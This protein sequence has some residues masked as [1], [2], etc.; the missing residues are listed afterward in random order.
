MCSSLLHASFSDKVSSLSLAP[1]FS[2]CFQRNS[3]RLGSI[4]ASPRHSEN[5]RLQWL[6]SK[7]HH[8]I[9]LHVFVVKPLCLICDLW[10]LFCIICYIFMEQHLIVMKIFVNNCHKN[11]ISMLSGHPR[12]VTLKYIKA[13]KHS[14]SL[15]SRHILA[16]TYFIIITQS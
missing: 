7:H 13:W 15:A 5:T 16:T 14:S 1:T 9:V 12:N 8:F 10:W 4:G 3:F 11:T 6:M 2:V